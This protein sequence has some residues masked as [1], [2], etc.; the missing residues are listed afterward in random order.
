LVETAR[1]LLRHGA[2]PNAFFLPEDLPNNPLSCIYAATGLNNNPALALALLE[3]GANRNDGES[4]YHSTEHHDLACMKLLL[5]HDAKV[6]GT[7]AL[8][9]MLDSED[10]E[11]LQLLLDAG[12]DPNETNEQGATALHLGGLAFAKR[13]DHYCPARSRRRPERS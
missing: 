12:A 4:L 11:G 3:G 9:H 6:E 2:D 5:S 13:K 7:N 10:S 1:V 8:K